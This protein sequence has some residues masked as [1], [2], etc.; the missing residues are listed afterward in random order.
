MVRTYKPIDKQVPAVQTEQDL[1]HDRYAGH[2]NPHNGT[3]VAWSR[4]GPNG[5]GTRTARKT[6]LFKRKRQT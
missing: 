6:T 4:V 5:Y 3:V 2:L 1:E